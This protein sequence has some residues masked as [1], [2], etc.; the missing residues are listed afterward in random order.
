MSDGGKKWIKKKK[1]EYRG[2]SRVYMFFRS[3]A[4]MGFCLLFLFS[5]Y[6][7]EKRIPDQIYV[8]EGETVSWD[9]DV[10]VTV[11]LK[12]QAIETSKNKG[13]AAGGVE[14]SYAVE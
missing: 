8:E 1:K 4:Y 14:T 2:K 13:R 5:V 3:L 9:F 12:D 7:L 10:P 6:T 11:V